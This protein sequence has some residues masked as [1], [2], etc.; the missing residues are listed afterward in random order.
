VLTARI[1]GMDNSAF[2]HSTVVPYEQVDLSW[3]VGRVVREVAYF[4]VDYWRF[5]FEP[6][7]YIQTGCLWRIVRDN[8]LILT[9][10]DHGQQFGLPAPIDAGS[11]VMEEFA[12]A[13]VRTVVLREATGDLLIE[14]EQ[15]LRLEIISMSSGYEAWEVHGPGRVCFVAQ[16][17]GQMSTWIEPVL[18]DLDLPDM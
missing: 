9:S 14:F 5:V 3:I 16:G 4:E 18:Q 11:K 12:S 6:W 10:Q 2:I 15:G 7:E 1:L 13:P 17:G 8:R